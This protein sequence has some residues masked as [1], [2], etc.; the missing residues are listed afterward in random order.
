MREIYERG[1]FGPGKSRKQVQKSQEGPLKHQSK[2]LDASEI[3]PPPEPRK[4]S[5]GGEWHSPKAKK[6]TR[7]GSILTEDHEHTK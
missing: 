7:G 1:N 4:P 5:R 3:P 6:L 2:P